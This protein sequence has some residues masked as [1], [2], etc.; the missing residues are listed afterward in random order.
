LAVLLHSYR[1]DLIELEGAEVAN[2][3]NRLQMV[4]EAMH[5]AGFPKAYDAD[6]FAGPLPLS[7][8]TITTVLATLYNVLTAPKSNNKKKISLENAKDSIRIRSPSKNSSRKSILSPLAPVET[9]IMEEDNDVVEAGSGGVESQAPLSSSLQQDRLMEVGWEGEISLNTSGFVSPLPQLFREA[10]KENCGVITVEQL[11]KAV[12]HCLWS[13]AAAA[14][15]ESP[16]ISS[17]S[18]LRSATRYGG[19]G[20][21]RLLPFLILFTQHRKISISLVG[22]DATRLRQQLDSVREG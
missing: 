3:P 13:S 21:G 8:R 22:G 15:P 4:F 7:E 1:P 16:H 10:D 18:P 20:R 19:R 6:D 14:T 12:Q 9:T 5:T 17:F 11:S 2:I